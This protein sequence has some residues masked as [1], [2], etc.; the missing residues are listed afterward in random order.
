MD[1]YSPPI[2][3]H[4][5]QIR[6]GHQAMWFRHQIRLLHA[7]FLPQNIANQYKSHVLGFFSSV[8]TIRHRPY[9][10]ISDANQLQVEVAKER[11][12]L[13]FTLQ[14]INPVAVR[15]GSSSTESGVSEFK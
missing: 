5:I 1:N 14:N 12:T 7:T 4:F 11:I 2:L 13:Y 6:Y 15:G 10:G 3:L 8:A 9:L